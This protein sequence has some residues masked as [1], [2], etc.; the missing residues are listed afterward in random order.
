MDIY[1]LLEGLST[2]VSALVVLNRL[3][4]RMLKSNDVT[5]YLKKSK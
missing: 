1:F 5:E 4:I 3:I 2:A